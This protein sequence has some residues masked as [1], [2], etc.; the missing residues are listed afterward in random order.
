MHLRIS[1]NVSMDIVKSN[2]MDI[3]NIFLDIHNSFLDPKLCKR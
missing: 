3:Q 1:K 2:F